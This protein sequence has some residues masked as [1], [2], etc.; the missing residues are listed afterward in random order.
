MKRE[1]RRSLVWQRPFRSVGVA[2][3]MLL[4]FA[5][6]FGISQ[7]LNA[8][9]EEP[10][11]YN[12]LVFSNPVAGQEDRYNKWYDSQHAPDVVA[13]P[14][15]VTAQRFVV[16][17]TQLR[18][19][20]PLPKYLVIY[21]IVTN[22]LPSVYAEVDRR[23]KTK[24]TVMDPSF[25]QTTSV[26]F[27]YKVIRPV[28]YHRGHQGDKGGKGADG[29]SHSGSQVYYQLVFT[30]PV[31]GKE[32]EYNQWYD[33]EH[34]PD[35]VAAPGFVS[36]QRYI[37]SDT[38]LREKPKTTKYFVMYKI[39]TNDIAA[40]FAQYKRLAPTMPTS[41]AFGESFGYTYKAIGSVIEGDKVRSERAKQK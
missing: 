35:V 33:K 12:L 19:S 15:F 18:I 1:S 28:I 20:K 21:K 9:K 25:D 30:D 16:S 13:V 8:Q 36:A 14:G 34:E 23:L 39:A 24:M 17:D 26:N 37:F 7:R 32:D 41:P 27:T 2:V 11:T 10:S 22:D 38:Q 31:A 40:D 4:A 6:C 3:G 29:A 5:A